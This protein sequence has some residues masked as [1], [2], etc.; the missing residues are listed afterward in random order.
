MDLSPQNLG[1]AGGIVVILLGVAGVVGAGYMAQEEWA[2]WL[3]IGTAAFGLA[4]V[5]AGVSAIRSAA[6]RVVEV[7]PKDELKQLIDARPVPFSICVRCR[8]IMDGAALGCSACGS[9]VDCVQIATEAE[10]T[11]GRAALG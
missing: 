1:R 9:V 3:F 7:M 2:A 6:P 10:R 8:A 4:F 5:F 11:M